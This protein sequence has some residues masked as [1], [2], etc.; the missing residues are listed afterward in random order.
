VE[1]DLMR[2]IKRNHLDLGTFTLEELYRVSFNTLSRR[3]PKNNTI[4]ASIQSNLQK[5]RDDGYLIFLNRGE[6]KVNNISNDE[7]INFVSNCHN[8]HK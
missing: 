4:K 5:L 6:Y 8:I 3:Y 7:F 1:N 2:I